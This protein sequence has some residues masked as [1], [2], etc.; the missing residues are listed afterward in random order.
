MRWRDHLNKRSYKQKLQILQ[1][2]L[3]VVLNE[4]FHMRMRTRAKYVHAL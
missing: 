4:A 1:G 3:L 2:R